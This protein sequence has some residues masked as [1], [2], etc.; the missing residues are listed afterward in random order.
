MEVA[1]HN[2]SMSV[3]PLIRGPKGLKLH[4][5]RRKFFRI[6]SALPETIMSVTLATAVVGAAATILVKRTKES[7]KRCR[8]FYLQVYTIAS[9]QMLL[10]LTPVKMCE[11]CGGSGICSECKGEGFVL[12]KLSEE[13]AARARMISKD[14]ATRYTSGLPRKWSYCTRCSSARNCRTCNGSGNLSL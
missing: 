2:R 13:R 4:D 10:V 1:F 8:G 7:E 6:S 9:S 11:D 3:I 14:A 12:Q 5:H